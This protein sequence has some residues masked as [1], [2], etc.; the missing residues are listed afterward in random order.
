MT[1]G[2]YPENLCLNVTALLELIIPL[3]KS[4]LMF[5][6]GA[7]RTQ[8]LMHSEQLQ[9]AKR[10]FILCYAVSA[11]LLTSCTQNLQLSR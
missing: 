7:G 8:S 1:N 6:R 10:I 4:S 3:F 2:N 5:L 9:K 11:P